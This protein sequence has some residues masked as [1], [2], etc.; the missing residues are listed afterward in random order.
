MLLGIFSRCVSLSGIARGSLGQPACGGADLDDA[1][2]D[3][4]WRRR[5]RAAPG[6]RQAERAN[7]NVGCERADKALQHGG[8]RRAVFNHVFAGLIAPDDAQSYLAGV[9]LLSAAPCDLHR[10]GIRLVEPDAR[11][12][13]LYAGA[14]QHE[15]G[16]HD[17][18]LRAHRRF[19]A[20]CPQDTLLLSMW[21]YI[22]LPLLAGYKTRRNLV[23]KKTARQR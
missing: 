2:S 14:S 7:R 17:L 13:D 23:G 9:I 10:D 11:G 1:V 18:G 15:R 5:R 20:R 16:D 4:G 22:M 3:D 6:G 12:R 8:A 19:A 21:L